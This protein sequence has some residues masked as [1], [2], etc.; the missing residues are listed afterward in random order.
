MGE[1]FRIAAGVVSTEVDGE[2]T[3]LDPVLGLYFGLEDA[4]A[5]V[6]RILAHEPD[7]ESLVV[8]LRQVFDVDEATCREDL[9]ALLTDLRQRG[10]IETRAG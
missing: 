7:F 5:A 1:R 4:G 6:W 3:V 9:A 2:I 10:L 8:H